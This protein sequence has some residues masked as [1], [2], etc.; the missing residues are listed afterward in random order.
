MIEIYTIYE[1]TKPYKPSQMNDPEIVAKRERS[2][3]RSVEFRKWMDD[4]G[5]VTP[6]K[7]KREMKRYEPMFV[8]YSLRNTIVYI[9]F[10]LPDRY[11]VLNNGV[12]KDYLDF[13]SVMH[14]VYNLP[15]DVPVFYNNGD[16]KK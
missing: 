7:N 16:Q 14:D 3:A 9:V 11:S 10:E 12:W 8:E 6:L 2:A 5:I 13:S 1:D 4:N 15:D